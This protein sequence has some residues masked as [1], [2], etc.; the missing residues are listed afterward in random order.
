MRKAVGRHGIAGVRLALAHAVHPPMAVSKN[1]VGGKILSKS[2]K[3]LHFRL[4]AACPIRVSKGAFG[5]IPSRGP[6]EE[7][8]VG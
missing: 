5:S 7:C 4:N 3:I 6:A 2:K 8:R 1:S